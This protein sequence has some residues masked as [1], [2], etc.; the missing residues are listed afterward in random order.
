VILRDRFCVKYAEKQGEVVIIHM[1][2]FGI[3]GQFVPKIATWNVKKGE[4]TSFVPLFCAVS[5]P[6]HR[7]GETPKEFFD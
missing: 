6:L 5:A 4:N 1:H 3:V 7:R 2:N